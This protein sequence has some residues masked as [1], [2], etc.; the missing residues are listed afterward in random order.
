MS[1]MITYQE[2]REFF[3]PYEDKYGW[4]LMA[5]SGN[6]DRTDD[7][8]R[9]HFVD[10]A[11]ICIVINPTNKGFRFIKS[12]DGVFE[13]KSD[14]CTTFDYPNHFERLY[15]RFRNIVITKRLD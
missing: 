10:D 3:K 11:N 9:Y 12:V 14:E 13:L 6:G 2:V 5:R 8:Y 7:S 4:I 1:G 15:L